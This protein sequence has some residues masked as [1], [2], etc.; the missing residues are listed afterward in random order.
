MPGY[1]DRSA[2]ALRAVSAGFTFSDIELLDAVTAVAAAASRADVAAAMCRVLIELEGV[3]G[4]AIAVRADASA[5]V[6]GSA[7]YPCDSMAPGAR[8]PLDSGLPVAE[9]IRTGHLVRAGE[10]PGWLAIPFGR[11]TTAPGAI[12]LSLTAAPPSREAELAR[13]GRLATVLGDAL[14]RAQ[15]AD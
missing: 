11:R 6:V 4:V 8:V 13:L 3:R 15:V 5:L 1:R 7:G 14:A 2:S 12:L 9:A 10:G